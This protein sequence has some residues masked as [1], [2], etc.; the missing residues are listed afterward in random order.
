MRKN[1]ELA[2]FTSAPTKIGRQRS[3][4][5]AEP[6]PASFYRLC[7]RN[8]A[9][10]QGAPPSP[11]SGAAASADLEGDR[12]EPG[13]VAPTNLRSRSVRSSSATSSSI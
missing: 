4:W 12:G 11:I 3:L 13:V 1:S 6:S 9:A 10:R 7:G 2:D 5:R 8:G